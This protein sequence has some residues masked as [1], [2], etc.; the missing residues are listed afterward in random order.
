MAKHALSLFI[1]IALFT[2]VMLIVAKVIP[3]DGLVDSITGLFDFHSASKFTRFILGEPD[4]EVWESLGDYFSILINT[5]ISVP[6]TSVVITA[7]RAVT[8]KVSLINIFREWVGST[9]RRFA[10]IFGFT[11]LFWALFRLLPYQSIFPDQTYSDFTIAAIVGFQLLLTIVC[12]WF[13][14]KKIITKRSL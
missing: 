10:K 11:F 9:R 6:I 5:L 12:Y 2:A 14:V 1:K 13:I 8:R 3:Y 4:L 7:Y